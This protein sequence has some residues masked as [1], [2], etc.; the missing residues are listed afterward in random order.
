[1]TYLRSVDPY[2]WHWNIQ[3]KPIVSEDDNKWQS[4]WHYLL[5]CGIKP[6]TTYNNKITATTFWYN[7]RIIFLK[8]TSIY[9]HKCTCTFITTI[10]SAREWLCNDTFTIL[11]LCRNISAGKSCIMTSHRSSHVVRTKLGLLLLRELFQKN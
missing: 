6:V 5:Q 3:K 4:F 11:G 1:M 8:Y 7:F 9:R 2:R 10:V